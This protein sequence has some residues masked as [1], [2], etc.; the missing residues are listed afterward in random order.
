[1]EDAH[2]LLLSLNKE[3]NSAFFAV[4]DGH[5][6]DK[7]AKFAGAH[8][9]KNIVNQPEFSKLNLPYYNVMQFI[10]T[11]LRLYVKLVLPFKSQELAAVLHGIMHISYRLIFLI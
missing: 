11:S 5:L 3:P 1:M 2:T 9:H 4:F 7:V 10:L 6:G 8:L